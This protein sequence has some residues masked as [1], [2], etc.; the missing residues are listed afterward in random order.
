MEKKQ[1][2]VAIRNIIGGMPFAIEEGKL[3]STFIVK[4]NRVRKLCLGLDPINVP[5]QSVIDV[6]DVLKRNQS[7]DRPSFPL[8]Q[9]QTVRQR[10]D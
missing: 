3:L 7:L 2:L 4:M 5:K 8:L 9:P 10:S 1:R 6:Q